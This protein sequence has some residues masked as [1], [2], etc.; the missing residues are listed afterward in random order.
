[1]TLSNRAIISLAIAPNAVYVATL[2]GLMLV[3]SFS[4]LELLPNG[5][6]PVIMGL[7]GFVPLA[8][9]AIASF[10]RPRRDA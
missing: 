9:I 3:R 6:M 8:S 1:M 7:S 2:I 10:I 4:G 5:S